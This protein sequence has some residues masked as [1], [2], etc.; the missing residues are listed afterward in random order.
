MD[1]AYQRA[2]MRDRPVL[3]A[4]LWEP[5]GGARNLTGKTANGSFTGSPTRAVRG[6]VGGYAMDFP[7]GTDWRFAH[8]A[9]LTCGDFWS[10]ETWFSL[11]NILGLVQL[12]GKFD[13]GYSMDYYN[14]VAA[15]RAENYGV[16][17]LAR[18]TIP[19]VANRWY[20]AVCTKNGGNAKVYINGKDETVPVGNAVSASSAGVVF[21]GASI[22]GNQ[23][24]KI[25]QVA[26][27]NY[28]LSHAQIRRHY[29]IATR[30]LAVAA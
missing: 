25:A 5:A 16:N 2:V 19:Q 12:A 17:D 1:L 23:T 27:Y 6:P 14:G 15:V 8:E 20:Y 30:R 26:V 24:A 21:G 11:N 4:P 7:V 28:A 13:G 9:V 22:I 29:L 18:S 10:I 3:Y